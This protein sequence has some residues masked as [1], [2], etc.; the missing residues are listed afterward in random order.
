MNKPP[1]SIIGPC[2]GALCA[3]AHK[4][5]KIF[6]VG[7]EFCRNNQDLARNGDPDPGL[8]LWRP[9]ASGHAAA[10]IRILRIACPARAPSCMSLT[11]S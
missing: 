5:S 3:L 7:F 11:T 8:F 4:W 2:S 6:S 10:E 9:T 1:N